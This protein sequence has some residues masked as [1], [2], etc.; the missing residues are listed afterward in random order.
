[1]T[2]PEA[3]P[4]S[5]LDDDPVLVVSELTKIYPGRQSTTAVDRLSFALGRG[6]ILGLLGPNGEARR[7]PSRC[8]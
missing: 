4:E 1:M 7:R 2:E 3:E 8:S 5:D 6:E